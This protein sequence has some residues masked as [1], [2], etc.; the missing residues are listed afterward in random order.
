MFLVFI[1]NHF[2]H[3]HPCCEGVEFQRAGSR[4]GDEHGHKGGEQL[5]PVLE[6]DGDEDTQARPWVV[7]PH[8]FRV[9]SQERVEDEVEDVV[10][11]WVLPKL[12]LEEIVQVGGSACKVQPPVHPIVARQKSPPAPPATTKKEYIRH[13]LDIYVESYVISKL[14]GKAKYQTQNF[15]T[16][17]QKLIGKKKKRFFLPVL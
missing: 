11:G 3:E 16:D 14:L 9:G 2:N 15:K 6:R 10:K 4:G 13:P 12:F 8:D 1:S 17:W 5:P 7:D